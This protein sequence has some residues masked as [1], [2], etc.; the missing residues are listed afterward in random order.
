VFQL[1]FEKVI[2]WPAM[3]ATTPTSMIRWSWSAAVSTSRIVELKCSHLVIRTHPSE[4][5]QF[6]A[7]AIAEL[8]Q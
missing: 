1:C 4:V 2:G 7:D 6:I 8:E 3:A 5:T